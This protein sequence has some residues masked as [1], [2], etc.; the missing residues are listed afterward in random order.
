MS[1]SQLDKSGSKSSLNL[2]GRSSPKNTMSGLTTPVPHASQVG[3]LSARIVDFT[4]MYVIHNTIIIGRFTC[5][6]LIHLVSTVLFCTVYTLG[7][8]KGAMS[9]N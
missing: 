4:Y 1:K 2:A 8:C 6:T 5:Y 9:F 3:T 7:R